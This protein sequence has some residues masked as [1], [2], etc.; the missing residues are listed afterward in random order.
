MNVYRMELM[1]AEV[2]PVETGSKTLKDAINEAFRDWVTNIENTHYLIGS[3]VG[4]HPYPLIVR[5]FQSVIGLEVKEQILQKEGHMPDSII[6]C[7]GG[8]S[9]AM[10]IFHP[11]VE[12]TEV[13]LIAVEAGGKALKCTEKAAFHSASL[14]AGEEGILHGARTKVLRIK[15]ADP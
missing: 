12:N 9:N 8:G 2:K 1:G 13:K 6:A 15:R 7:A 4:P 3:V 14:C 11:F 5:D 10:G